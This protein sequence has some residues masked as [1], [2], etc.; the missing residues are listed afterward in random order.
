MLFITVALR[1]VPKVT[2]REQLGTI[3]KPSGFNRTILLLS[4]TVGMRIMPKAILKGAIADYSEAIRLK[5]DAIVFTNRGNARRAKGDHEGAEKDFQQAT[6]LKS[7]A[8]A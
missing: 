6:R 4:I 3:R 2:F 7:A 8:G 1:D 5:P